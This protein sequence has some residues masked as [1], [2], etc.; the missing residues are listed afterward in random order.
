[1]I[2][3]EMID[4]RVPICKC[5]Q[6]AL[7]RKMVKRPDYSGHLYFCTD[8]GTEYKIIGQGQ[9]ENELYFEYDN[10]KVVPFGHQYLGKIWSCDTCMYATYSSSCKGCHCGSN[11]VAR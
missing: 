3:R 7:D 10:G 4:I 1:M 6:G 2:I 8:C 5:C 9:A 11:Y